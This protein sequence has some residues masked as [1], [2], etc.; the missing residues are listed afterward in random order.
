MTDPDHGN[1]YVRRGDLDPIRAQ[2][3]EHYREFGELKAGL[4]GTE[5]FPGG[6]LG[7]I[8]EQLVLAEH[9][10]EELSRRLPG[11]I[12]DGVRDGIHDDRSERRDSMLATAGKVIVG[13]IILV[14]AGVVAVHT[15]WHT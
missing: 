4:L 10:L 3:A 2:L 1:G 15:G 9:R 5:L 11:M 7:R 6:R 12:A 8:T 13:V 14:L